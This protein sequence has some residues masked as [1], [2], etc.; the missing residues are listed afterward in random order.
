MKKFSYGTSANR[1]KKNSM[2]ELSGILT[3]GQKDSESNASKNGEAKRS[4][5]PVA[6]S[7]KK[8]V[9]SERSTSA[10]AKKVVSRRRVRI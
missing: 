8:T 9:S 3:S 7:D 10:K 2:M 4:V 1:K 6:S 5:P